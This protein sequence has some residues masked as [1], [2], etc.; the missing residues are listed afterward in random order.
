MLHEFEKEGC[1]DSADLTRDDAY[2]E[3]LHRICVIR[4]KARELGIAQGDKDFAYLME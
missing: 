1:K 3:A 2:A 4:L